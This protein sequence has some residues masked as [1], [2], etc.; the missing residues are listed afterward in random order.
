VLKQAVAL[1]PENDTFLVQTGR[2]LKAAGQREEA[3]PYYERALEIHPESVAAALGAVDTRLLLHAD[4]P[5]LRGSLEFLE[6]FLKLEPHNE[7]LIYYV[8]RLRDRI[9]RDAALEEAGSPEPEEPQP[10]QE[11]GDPDPDPEGADAG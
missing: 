1:A 11:G 9:Q 2:A 3:L 6:P 5:D 7:D 4:D 10:D 8:G